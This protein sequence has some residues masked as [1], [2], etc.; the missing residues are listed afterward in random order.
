[1]PGFAGSGFGTSHDLLDPTMLPDANIDPATSNFCE[2]PTT[3]IPQFPLE[4]TMNAGSTP[5]EV[6]GF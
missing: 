4:L 1:M 2:G 5:A 6:A 3:P